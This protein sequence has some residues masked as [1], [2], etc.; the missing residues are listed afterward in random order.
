MTVIDPKQ[1]KSKRFTLVK[2]ELLTPNYFNMFIV[3]SRLPLL[4][5]KTNACNKSETIDEKTKTTQ[6][7]INMSSFVCESCED[8]KTTP[9]PT[10]ILLRK[11]IKPIV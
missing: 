3:G 5:N 10:G 2:G 1:K 6:V 9:S 11:D 7:D 4:S 8:S